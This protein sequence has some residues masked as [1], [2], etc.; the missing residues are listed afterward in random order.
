MTDT[1]I[2]LNQKQAAKLLDVEPETL[3]K[4]RMRN[5]GPVYLRISGKIRYLK[6]DVLDYLAACRIVP[7]ERKHTR[8]KRA[9]K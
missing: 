6:S 5:R 4:W 8:R 3:S 9:K 1:E 2:K 7:S